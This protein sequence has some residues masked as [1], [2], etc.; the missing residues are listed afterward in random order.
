MLVAAVLLDFRV[1]H[2]SDGVGGVPLSLLQVTG[3]HV[4]HPVDHIHL[5]NTHGRHV[6][7]HLIRSEQ[8]SKI[9]QIKSDKVERKTQLKKLCIENGIS[10]VKLG[11]PLYAHTHART[12]THTLKNM[13]VS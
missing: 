9:K 4:V 7:L 3:P 8:I 13:S 1:L 2:V 6:N 12:H 11:A 10:F 5:K